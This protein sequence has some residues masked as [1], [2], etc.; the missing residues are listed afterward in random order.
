MT[1]KD[2]QG[3][4]QKTSLSGGRWEFFMS[5][6]AVSMTFVIDKFTGDVVQLVERKD[7]TLTWEFLRKEKSIL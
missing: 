1:E 7:K 3:T 5:D 2:N 6:V 4:N